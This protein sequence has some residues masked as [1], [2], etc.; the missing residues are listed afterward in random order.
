MGRTG[1]NVV[2]DLSAAVI[3]SDYETRREAREAKKA[4]KAEA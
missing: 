1:I 2:G 3:I 4:A